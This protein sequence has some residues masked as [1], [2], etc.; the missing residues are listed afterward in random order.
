MI[1]R[2]YIRKELLQTFFISLV[3]LNLTLMMEKLLKLSRLLSGLGASLWDVLRFIILVQPQLMLLTI[4]MALLL[5]V[6]ITYGRMALDNELLVLRT[7]GLRKRGLYEPVFK[8]SL[9]VMMAGF[10]ISL[11]LMPVSLRVLRHDV[12]EIIKK[13]APLAIEPG[14]F[15]DTFKGLTVLV[16]EKD[17]KAGFRDIFMYDSRKGA[18]KRVITAKEGR[19][20]FD[21]EGVVFTLKDGMVNTINDRGYTEIRFSEYLFRIAISGQLLSK[22]KNE[23]TLGE[24][25]EKIKSGGKRATGFYI[26]LHRRFTFPLMILVIAFLAP[27]LSLLS[28]KTG[29]VGG[30]FIAVIVFLLYYTSLL[31]F[32]NQVRTGKLNHLFCWMPFVLFSLIAFIS[33]RRVGE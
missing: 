1:I 6:L 7:S 9:V 5:S 21:Q 29:R 8:L 25:I 4:P 2:G 28:G 14:V 24:L 19:I 13:R 15:F 27:S 26:E 32:E 18:K 12:N 17:R 20:A 16:K 30:F 3:G 33:Y 31:Y 10:I 22:R 11:Y 23:M